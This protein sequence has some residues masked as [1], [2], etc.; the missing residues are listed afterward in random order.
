MATPRACLCLLRRGPC[1]P[2][3]LTSA[4]TAQR[5]RRRRPSRPAP[6]L[7]RRGGW[8]QSFS[9]RGRVFCCS[10]GH[11]ACRPALAAT[12]VA[13]VGA[14][15]MCRR[16]VVPSIP[17]PAGGRR[18]PSVRHSIRP[19][20]RRTGVSARRCVAQGPRL[21]EEMRSIRRGRRKMFSCGKAARKRN[22]G[23]VAR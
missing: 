17:P 18:V 23:G 13:S 12:R 1:V 11:R 8:A 4:D 5:H 7:I 19:A 21:P 16:L 10:K 20:R 2:L 3:T 14:D 22:N 15:L 6:R 9:G